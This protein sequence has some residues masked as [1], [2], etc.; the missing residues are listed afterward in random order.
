MQTMIPTIIV[1]E[2][3]SNMMYNQ[4]RNFAAFDCPIF[5]DVTI[6]NPLLFATYVLLCMLGC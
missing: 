1:V 2:R 5:N 3:L 6:P 4:I